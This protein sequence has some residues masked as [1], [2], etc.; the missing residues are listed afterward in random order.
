MEAVHVFGGID[1]FQDALGINLRGERELNSRMPSTLLSRFKSSTTASRSSVVTV[2]GG[3]RRA[4]DRPI[5]SQAAIL[6]LT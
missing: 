6:L 4:L 2:A 3:V 5:S 1:G